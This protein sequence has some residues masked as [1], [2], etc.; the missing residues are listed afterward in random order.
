MLVGFGARLLLEV[1]T[2]GGGDG[3]PHG[4]DGFS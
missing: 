2:N 3:A 4:G 1:Q